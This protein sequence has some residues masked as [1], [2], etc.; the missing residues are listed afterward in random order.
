MHI[1]ILKKK[2]EKSTRY[3]LSTSYAQNNQNR[4]EKKIPKENRTNT[5][6]TCQK[7]S[8]TIQ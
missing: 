3:N 6:N 4:K 5:D 2:K 1:D 7:L 8:L